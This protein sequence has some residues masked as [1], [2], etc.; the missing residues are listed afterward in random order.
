MII[1][2]LCLEYSNLL[3]LFDTVD[4]GH[5]QPS[6]VSYVTSEFSIAF[7]HEW[8][9][10]VIR[11]SNVHVVIACGQHIRRDS[12]E[13]RTTS[14]PLLL[15]LHDDT[16]FTATVFVTCDRSSTDHSTLLYVW[17]N[18]RA[19]Y[20]DDCLSELSITDSPSKTAG[21]QHSFELFLS[22]F[23][24]SNQIRV[25]N[26]FNSRRYRWLEV[27]RSSVHIYLSFFFP[28]LSMYWAVLCV[29]HGIYC[30]DLLLH[31]KIEAV[32]LVSML[33]IWTEW[34]DR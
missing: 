3:R 32:R 28:S 17:A 21:S 2:H 26:M 10:I 14:V 30:V 31:V 1:L 23:L 5:V 4:N 15:L 33:F 13:F 12:T 24:C 25:R 27:A 18:V 6:A 11:W 8:T 16:F 34:K 7:E 19:R 22:S 9:T 29:W 20:V